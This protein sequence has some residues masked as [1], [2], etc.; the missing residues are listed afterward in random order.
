M[1]L[2]SKISLVF[3]KKHESFEFRKHVSS[4]HY[5]IVNLLSSRFVVFM[6]FFFIILPIYFCFPIAILHMLLK[7]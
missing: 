5:M 4:V 6:H 7:Q 1:S 3:R 2:E